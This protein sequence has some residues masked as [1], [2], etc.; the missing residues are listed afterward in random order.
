MID[1]TVSHY[2]VIEKL[3]GGGMG[4]VYRA[5][6]TKLRRA[7]AIKVLPPELTRDE[8]AK[9]RFMLEA[10]AASALDH[11]NICTIHE[12]DETPDGQLFLVMA[13]Y[14]GET[15][16]KKI[17]R[18]PLPLDEALD[19]AIQIAQGL[20]KAH[21]AGII[22]RDLKP[23]NALVTSDGLVKIVDFGLAKLV[24]H[25]GMTRT[26]MTLG[27]LAYMSP[28]QTLGRPLDA[29][30]DIWSLGVLL[31]EMVAGQ[32]PFRGDHEFAVANAIASRPPAPLTSVRTGVPL[33]LERV[34]TRAL[35]KA[36]A[37]RHQTAADLLSELRRIKRASESQYVT[38]AGP[39]APTTRSLLQRPL[40]RW[41]MA[42]AIA[43][44][45]IGLIVYWAAQ[46]RELTAQVPRLANP[47]QVASS[48]AAEILPAWS[49]DG[50]MLAYTS[51]Q[52]GN[53]DIWIAQVG[54]GPPINRTADSNRAEGA[55]RWSPDGRQ[56]LFGSAVLGSIVFGGLDREPPGW[57]VMPSLAGTARR[58]AEPGYQSTAT[59]S[60]DGLEVAY[61][62]RDAGTEWLE[63]R[64]LR[65]G[66]TRR[67]ALPGRKGNGRLDTTW[68]PDGRF[69][70]YIDAR[71]YT[72][73]VSQLW[74]LRLGDGKAFP[75]SDGRMSEWS[76]SWAPDSRI[77]YFS[78]NRGGLRDLWR[79]RIADDGSPSGAAEQISTG[80]EMLNV[81]VSADGRRVAFDKGQNVGNLWRVPLLPDR[82]AVW[83]DAKQLTFD[84]AYVEFV[85]LSP[86]GH[87]L[88]ISSDR[89]GNPDLWILPAEGGDMQQ[90][91]TDPTPDW[92][93]AWSP[94]GTEIAFYAY[95]SGNREVWVQPLGGGPA[96]QLTRGDVESLTPRWSPNGKWLA[97]MSRLEGSLD[98]WVVPAAGGKARPIVGDP[99]WTDGNP[100]WTRDGQSIVFVSNRSGQ[101]RLWRISAQGGEVQPVTQG[102]GAF[103]IS[104]PDGGWIYFFSARGGSRQIWRVSADGKT[105]RPVTDFSGRRGQLATN[106]LATDGRY[107][108]FTWREETGDIWVADLVPPFD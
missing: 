32:I 42:A 2:R 7:V 66:T 35:E 45:V 30:S 31:Y 25:S 15:L 97:F 19:Y 102:P 16:K 27:T 96:R 6:D 69:V 5:E 37:D 80:L 67:V 43:V 108:Y 85:D 14:A 92:A 23:A 52:G 21:G 51:N 77:L 53:P 93:P 88:A 11:P 56:I 48:T 75:L 78:S 71:N 99:A 63:I 4:V 9:Q 28:E 10:Q 83:A 46:P 95:R 49:P 98:V 64:S 76:P 44:P 101:G 104:S 73:Q 12:I 26:G 90:L 57:F 58:I 18:G 94:D 47:I 22:H 89:T 60:P 40:A 3:G 33:E 41:A 91:T 81:S 62:R 105:E 70:A 36:P 34:V 8:E 87:R 55:A 13:Y 74:V 86:D 54:G 79:Q 39:P 106:A 100:E 72:L 68:S 24:G 1:Q 65:D 20:V 82:A 84:K 50:R 29:R 103:P 17:E 38:A 61:P 59:W 107:I